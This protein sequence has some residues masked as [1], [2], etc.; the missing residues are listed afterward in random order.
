MGVYPT[1]EQRVRIKPHWDHSVET[2]C[3]NPNVASA[4]DTT[5]GR[6]VRGVTLLSTR[7][8]LPTPQTLREG[9]QACM[10]VLVFY[11]PWI[12]LRFGRFLAASHTV[13]PPAL[14]G[15]CLWRS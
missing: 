9:Q 10:I 11:H 6:D 14:M 5:F 15:S 7:T 1:L 8:V 2:V 4:A 12:F 3:P 13:L